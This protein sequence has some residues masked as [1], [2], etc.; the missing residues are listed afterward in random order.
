MSNDNEKPRKPVSIWLYILV[1]AALLAFIRAYSALSPIILSF[2]L[3]ILISLALN[4][5]VTWLRT[6]T[7]GRKTAIGVVFG[8]LIVALGLT[9]WAF[10][11]PLKDSVAGLVEVL[12]TYWE[13]LQKPLI[14]METQAARSE[15]K[16][17]EQV[18]Q[19]TKREEDAKQEQSSEP[20]YEN[21]GS[22]TNSESE[23][24][25]G[26]DSN[27]SLSAASAPSGSDTTNSQQQNSNT[28]DTAS[29]DKDGESSS[30]N[31]Q[32]S[33]KDASPIRSSIG[34]ALQGIVGTFS[35]AAFNGAQI[36]VVLVTVF[37]GVIFMLLNP[38]PII[39]WMFAVVPE[40]HHDKAL[41]ILKRI[42][43]FAPNWGWSTLSGMLA[44][45]LLVF[46]LMWPILGLMDAIVLG[47]IAGLLEAVPFL[48]PTLSVIP[49]MLLAF[50]QGGMTPVWVLLAYIGVQ[51]LENNVILPMI[52]AR[53][54][55]LHAVAVIFSMFL[56]VAAFG[57]LG[58]LVAAPLVAIVSIVHEELYRKKFLPSTDKTDLERLAWQALYECTPEDKAHASA[59]G[60][61]EPK[62]CH[63]ET[64]CAA[65]NNSHASK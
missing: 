25:A 5:F 34:Q 44:I 53:G 20:N 7:G 58:V 4:P 41:T 21:N 60:E 63:A 48:G 49:G 40:R 35:A 15:Q 50:G 31:D 30:S 19:E 32:S 12:P 45:G 39:E 54:M 18:K 55:Q 57:V 47:V 24:S 27:A 62:N 16:L 3:T 23:N 61:S 42:C 46:L 17:Q 36:L 37:F 38:K 11:T 6:F 2:L 10:Y 33:Q 28:E 43:Q 29:D 9:G 26:M 13:R 51:I 22:A 52:M 8:L 59:Q 64:C 14:K 65:N 56:C 1:A